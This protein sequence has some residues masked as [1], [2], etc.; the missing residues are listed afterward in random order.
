MKPTV[1]VDWKKVKKNKAEGPLEVL[2]LLMK[3]TASPDGPGQGAAQA[4][5]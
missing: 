4:F 5:S 1:F 3:T 2:V